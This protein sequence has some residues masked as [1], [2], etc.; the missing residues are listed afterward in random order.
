MKILL[1]VFLAACL[2]SGQS[3]VKSANGY[4]GTGDV[5]TGAFP[6]TSGNL[7]WVYIG[8]DFLSSCP[9]FTVTDT[10]GNTFAQIGSSYFTL[11]GQCAAQ[12]YAKNITGSSSNVVTVHSSTDGYMHA[13]VQQASG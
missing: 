13:V 8:E 5:T 1:F 11:F 10:V 12:F 7:L 6:T 2:C 9:T 3:F 4:N